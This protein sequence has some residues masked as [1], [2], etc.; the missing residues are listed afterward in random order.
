MTEIGELRNQIISFTIKYENAL[1]KQPQSILEF[2]LLED[3]LKRSE[4]D[5]LLVNE[6]EED[7]KEDKTAEFKTVFITDRNNLSK[8][9]S[10]E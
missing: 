5:L 1:K 2:E 7:L 4:S 3:E 6:T 9:I 8:E 10:I